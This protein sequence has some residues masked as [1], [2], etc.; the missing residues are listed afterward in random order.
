VF[1]INSAKLLTTVS[2]AATSTS[3]P[4]A[5]SQPIE[6]G[7]AMFLPTTAL[8]AVSATP[9]KLHVF[10]VGN[11][12][13]LRYVEYTEGSGWGPVAAL[14][15]AMDF[16]SPHTRIAV[17]AFSATRVEVAAISDTGNLRIHALVRSWSTWIEDSSNELRPPGEIPIAVDPPFPLIEKDVL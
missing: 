6:T 2:W 4:G 8:A 15:T 1:V 5:T 7:P 11:D 3:W 9:T 16:V 17:H 13:K 10:G 12:L 14:G